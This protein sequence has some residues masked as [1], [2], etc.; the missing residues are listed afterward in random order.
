MIEL[1]PSVSAVGPVKVSRITLRQVFQN[2]IVNAAEAVQGAAGERGSL[3]IAADVTD[4]SACPQLHLTFSDNGV[5]ISADH[6]SR[7]FERGFS[8]EPS[9]TNSGIGLQWCAN[10][11]AHNVTFM[12]GPP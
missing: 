11:M 4:G 2:F 3:R 12:T 9:A 8:T 1:D 6:L 5:G 7:I 10:A